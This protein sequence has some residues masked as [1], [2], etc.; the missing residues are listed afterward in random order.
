AGGFA[1]RVDFPAPAPVSAA[2]VGDVTGDGKL[3]VVAAADLRVCVF[4]GD[5]AGH[6]AAPTSTALGGS[7]ATSQIWGIALGDV[8]KDGD[9]DVVAN[10]NGPVVELRN[11]GSGGFTRFDYGSA[12]IGARHMLISDVTGDGKADVVAA[13]DVAG[14]VVVLTG[15]GSG[16]LAQQP[17]LSTGGAPWHVALPDLAGAGHPAAPRPN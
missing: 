14:G 2:V 16:N 4:A 6:L 8:D 9:V 15:D 17:T 1:P 12:R 11:D 7:L 10:Y 3:D 5:G 13:G